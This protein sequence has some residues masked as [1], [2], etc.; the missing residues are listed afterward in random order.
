MEIII[1]PKH[2]NGF[3]RISRMGSLKGAEHE[4]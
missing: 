1:S 3:R 2:L 4:T